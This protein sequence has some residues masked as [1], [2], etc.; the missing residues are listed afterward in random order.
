[1]H[2]SPFTSK[3]FEQT[4]QFYNHEIAAMDFRDPIRR[5][6]LTAVYGVCL[7]TPPTNAIVCTNDGFVNYKDAVPSEVRLR[8]KSLGIVSLL[9]K[10]NIFAIVGGGSKPFWSTN[11]VHTLHH[12]LTCKKPENQKVDS[13][14]ITLKRRDHHP[15]SSADFRFLGKTRS[16]YLEQCLHIIGRHMERRD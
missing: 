7:S 13:L 14:I 4:K 1:M 11:K 6:Q 5:R 3:R 12:H 16:L 9:E 10:S 15:R 8:G 2:T